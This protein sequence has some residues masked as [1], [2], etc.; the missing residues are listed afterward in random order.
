MYAQV[1]IIAIDNQYNQI[2]QFYPSFKIR[3]RIQKK[4][5]QNN[6]QKSRNHSSSRK[7]NNSSISNIQR[8]NQIND[9]KYFVLDSR[10]ILEKNINIP[11]PKIVAT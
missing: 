6:H 3:F 5:Q 10:I 2:I 7:S 8:Y 11:N 9:N 4:Q 1:A